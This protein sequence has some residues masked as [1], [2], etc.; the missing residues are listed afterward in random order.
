S[1][2]VELYDVGT[3]NKRASL[4]GHRGEISSIAFSPAGK[5]L[6][7]GSQD[8]TVKLWDLASGQ[9]RKQ[10]PY[11]S[12][13][14]SVGFSSDGKLLAAGSVDG[15]VKLWELGSAEAPNT[16]KHEG[17]VRA[18]VFSRDGQTLISAGDHP[19]KLW[20]V[21]TGKEKATL[22]GPLWSGALSQH[23]T[24]LVARNLD[25]TILVWD[26]T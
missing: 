2:T 5:T 7:S 13:V 20:D 8:R 22:Q 1:D 21:A 15:I 23:G 25:K 26:L 11:L 6:V 3:G 24:T 18:V 17:A 14:H 12:P 4:Q 10:F 9:E 16:L 19:T